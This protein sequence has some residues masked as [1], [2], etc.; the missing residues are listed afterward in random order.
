LSTGWFDLVS[1]A[2][3][4][5]AASAA[6]A[7]LRALSVPFAAGA[8]LRRWLY[9][10]G[11]LQMHRATIPVISVGNIC[12]GGTG[13][14]PL[15]EYLARGLMERSRRPAVIMRGYR[16]RP[17][18]SGDEASML[19]AA[20]GA[21]V[22]VI[23]DPFRVRGCET[24]V[25]EAGADVAILD[26]GFQHL[27]L[28]RDLDVV[29]VDATNP[30]GFGRLLPAGCLREKPSALRRADAIV[31]TRAQLV[32]KPDLDALHARLAAT[33]PDA[34]VL[35]SEYTPH[36]LAGLDGAQR[37]LEELRGAPVAAFSGIGNP[38]AFGLTLRRLGARIVLAKR[39]ADHHPFSHAEISWVLEEAA[40]RGAVFVLTTRK[41]AQRI[42][43]EACA[44]S[45]A[46]PVCVVDARL[47]IRAREPELWD[48]VAR[49]LGE[50]PGAK[51]P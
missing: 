36:A 15:V 23:E 12:V 14:T 16:A 2:A 34:Y 38:H 42:P 30:F 49:A 13:K 50:T 47:T 41:D 9:R 33:A 10:R 18:E 4:G 51:T 25:V 46:P 29:V 1:G 37:S 20:F 11:V 6:R 28:C 45:G 40:R 7:G 39:Y 35:E 32:P 22:A 27:A 3:R 24:A 21:G 19:R 48:L 5:P 26:D 31:I 44:R 8:R 43:T 17:G